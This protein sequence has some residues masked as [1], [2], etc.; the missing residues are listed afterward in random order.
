MKTQ[1]HQKKSAL[2]ISLDFE[3][4]WGV[5]DKRGIS[6]YGENVRG[7]HQVI[8]RMLDLF[9]K[10]DIHVT[11][12]VV[13]LLFHNNFEELKGE[14]PR[15]IPSYD[16]NRFS[17]Y[18]HFSEIKQ[19]DYL[20]YYSGL[21]LIK[22]IK[23]VSGQEIG[24]HTYSHYYCLEEGQNLIAF[25][26]DIKKAI[27]IAGKHDLEINSIVFPRNQYN[28]EYLKI[29][30]EHGI[31]AFRGN[32]ENFSQ[33]P[34]SEKD[35]T[36]LMRF[37]RLIDTYINIFGQKVIY[38]FQMTQSGM[39][40]VPASF[41]FRPYGKFGQ[42]LESLKIRRYKRAML[43][44]AKSNGVIHFWWHPHNFGINQEKNLAQ[45]EMI[46]KYYKFLNREFGMVSLNMNEVADGSKD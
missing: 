2:V 37:S 39:V 12:A 19:Q 45:L 33:K 31:K 22:K 44:A 30:Y 41:F 42:I 15:V 16:D 46:L 25:I 34:S 23:N 38:K 14:V 3:L 20:P 8:P 11:W 27:T 1:G 18:S 9:I 26:E 43:S 40:N 21:E 24:T 28:N 29:C 36:L 17:A 32:E 6:D 5:F 7:V 35:L 10:Y 13:G 4:M